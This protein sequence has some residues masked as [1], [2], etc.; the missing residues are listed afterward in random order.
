MS[1][2][3][4][5]ESQRAGGLVDWISWL[6]LMLL[7]TG[8]V[9]HAW[10]HGG[11]PAF[12]PTADAFPFFEAR[13]AGN[14][15]AQVDF[16]TEASLASNPR[17]VFYSII[18][19]GSRL[20]GCDYFQVLTALFVIVGTVVPILLYRLLVRAV[21][22][23]YRTPGGQVLIAAGI[24]CWTA[25]FD[26]RWA[27]ASWQPL[28]LD[29]SAQGLSYC[30][31]LPAAAGLLSTTTSWGRWLWLLPLAVATCIHPVNA[32]AVA[33]FVCMVDA[34]RFDLRRS[35]LRWL[36]IGIIGWLLPALLIAFVFASELSLA[37]AVFID[38]YARRV[39]P[40]HYDVGMLL[41]QMKTWVTLGPALAI[42][43]VL[44]VGHRRE[45]RSAAFRIACWT[46][47]FGPV[48]LL[49]Q[50]LVVEVVPSPRF[51]MLGPTR[52]LALLPWLIVVSLAVLIGRHDV[53]TGSPTPA[54]RPSKPTMAVMLGAVILLWAAWP[55]PQPIDQQS[56][57]RQEL[58]TWLRERTQVDDV[59]VATSLQ[60]EAD[61][62][63][64][65][66]RAVVLG[67]NF[68]FNPAVMDEFHD[69]WRTRRAVLA[70]QSSAVALR[71]FGVTYLVGEQ[72]WQ[73][74]DAVEPLDGP[75]GWYVYRIMGGV[76]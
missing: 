3:S 20:F 69:R 70:G 10:R 60:L 68:P 52:L 48:V 71:R 43:A 72:P 66:G 57:A 50:W 33:I 55:K 22:L 31:A 23:E 11:I 56:T 54:S 35:L 53:S 2:R 12:W 67:N 42:G 6:P 64:F 7:L 65:T 19:Q 21:P 39:Q 63:Q 61:I 40:F 27:I 32:L 15:L 74:S 46:L 41:G 30:F 75:P 45:A 8:S 49:L 24:A 62:R 9:L 26:H 4:R 17:M 28:A 44:L 34:V 51:V 1:R 25:V 37:E 47:V 73:V 58:F 13:M 36:S 14:G 76:R 16:F 5:S 59:I 29:A 38:L 18:E